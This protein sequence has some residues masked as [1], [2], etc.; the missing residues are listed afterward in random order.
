MTFR[1]SYDQTFTVSS[2]F[3]EKEKHTDFYTEKIELTIRKS[4]RSWLLWI[5]LYLFLAYVAIF[6]VVST[7]QNS[8]SWSL[9]RSI[10]DSF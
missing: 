2:V 4:Y 1:S 8:Q 5:Q 3:R 10:L 9:D 7:L 6:E